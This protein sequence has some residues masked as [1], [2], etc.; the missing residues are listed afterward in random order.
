MTVQQ[1]ADEIEES[2]LRISRCFIPGM[3]FTFVARQPGNDETALIKTDDD[4]VDVSR[5]VKVYA[6]RD[7]APRD[8]G[9]K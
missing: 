4:L 7:L 6:E 8:S 9:G 3:K 1:V 5:L 2:M